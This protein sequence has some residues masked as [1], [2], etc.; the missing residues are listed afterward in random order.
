M[1]TPNTTEAVLSAP[2]SVQFIKM[3]KFT[4][5]QMRALWALWNDPLMREALDRAAG[6]SNGPQLVADLIVKGVDI[7]CE[8]V[9]RIDRDGRACWPGLYSLTDKGRATLR[10]WGWGGTL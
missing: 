8:L 9:R 3:P 2:S 6:V 1:N 4:S 10:G 5:R 7:H